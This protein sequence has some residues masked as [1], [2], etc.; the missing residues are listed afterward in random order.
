MSKA[1]KKIIA[2]VR[3]ALRAVRGDV[4]TIRKLKIINGC[5]CPLCDLDFKIESGVHRLGGKH[6]DIAC[7]RLK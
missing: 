5:G 1:G 6:G 7:T 2:G 3:E 4:R